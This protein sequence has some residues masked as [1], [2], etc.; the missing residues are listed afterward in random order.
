MNL[1]METPMATTGHDLSHAAW[2]KSTHSGS[3]NCIETA[4]GPSGITVRD[5]ADPYGPIL[6]FTY[7]AWTRFVAA[8]KTD[9]LRP[10]PLSS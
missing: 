4:P 1:H 9:P 2:R 7:R 5:S 10:R 6:A 3:G 8:R